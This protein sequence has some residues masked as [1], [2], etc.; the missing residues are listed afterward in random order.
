MWMM[1]PG[2]EPKAIAVRYDGVTSMAGMTGMTS[3]I[4]VMG[5]TCMAGEM[6]SW[7]I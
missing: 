6:A 1:G 3:M 7:S 4:G 5:V 2:N